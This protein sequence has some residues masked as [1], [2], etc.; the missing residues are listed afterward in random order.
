MAKSPRDEEGELL[1]AAGLPV[2]T[3]AAGT[4]ARDGIVEWIDID[5]RFFVGVLRPDRLEH[6]SQPR[7]RADDFQPELFGGLAPTFLADR[8][9][10]HLGAK[11]GPLPGDGERAFRIGA[12]PPGAR[13]DSSKAAE[14]ST[15]NIPPHASALT[16]SS[17]SACS[18]TAS[19]AVIL[20]TVRQVI[21]RS[22]LAAGSPQSKPTLSHG[23]ASREGAKSSSHWTSSATVFT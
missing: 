22:T 23:S 7:F 15:S 11:E 12:D 18:A 8:G 6:G 3:D 4:G 2:M 19:A 5:G 13:F 14:G 1:E 16:P 20:V 17:R 21:N 10:G 9:I